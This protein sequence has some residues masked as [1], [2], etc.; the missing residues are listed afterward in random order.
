MLLF[1]ILFPIRNFSLCILVDEMNSFRLTNKKMPFVA[2]KTKTYSCKIKKIIT[3]NCHDWIIKVMIK[4]NVRT[5]N[6][7]QIQFF[8]TNKK[9]I[10]ER[11]Q[12]ENN[13]RKNCEE[14]ERLKMWTVEIGESDWCWL[15]RCRLLTE[16]SKLNSFGVEQCADRSWLPIVDTQSCT[17][18]C[19]CLC[20]YCA[21]ERVSCF[22]REFRSK[23]V[24]ALCMAIHSHR[25][26]EWGSS[27]MYTWHNRND[28]VADD[29][30]V[31]VVVGGGGGGILA[32]TMSTRIALSRM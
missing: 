25:V 6:S 7:N 10:P 11:I 29:V 24:V 13:L 3:N 28:V 8:H 27:V 17:A 14:S 9:K 2:N 19:C 15:V 1:T 16:C 18:V 5:K 4:I 12:T 26:P 21:L 22:V 20:L 23:W 32:V 30:V 31:I